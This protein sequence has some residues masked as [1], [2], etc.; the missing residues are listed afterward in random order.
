MPHR[1]RGK[2]TSLEQLMNN[3]RDET[4]EALAIIDFEHHEL[5]SGDHFNV[6]YSVADLGAATTPDDMMTLTFKTPNTTK[7]L[8]MIVA[9]VSSSGARFRFIEG[10]TGGGASPTGTITAYNS[11]RNNKPAS[12]ILN[13]S[14]VAGS[15]SYDATLVTGGTSLVDV[16]IGADGLGVS[17]TGGTARG[18]QEWILKANTQY[19]LSIFEADNVPGTLQMSWYEHTNVT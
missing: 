11:D 16:F 18:E 10:G 19:Q 2:H 1:I 5:H 13:L 17:F 4:T 15:V 7:W 3:A 12:T 9:A 6:Q 14:S 8:H